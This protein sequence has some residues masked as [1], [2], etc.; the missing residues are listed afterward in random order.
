MKNITINSDRQ[1]IINVFV[2]E[3]VIFY[4]FVNI[5]GCTI[6]D[7]TKVGSFVE[8]QKNAVIGK[9]CKISSHSFICEG[10]QI[11]DNTFIGHNVTFINDKYPQA[12]NDLGELKT[13]NDWEVVRTYIGNKVSIGSGATI[14]CGLQIGD[15]AVIGAGSV[16]TKDVQAGT[17]VAGNPA[18]F[19]KKL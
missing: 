1:S 10:V 13:E 6:G 12:I 19:R 18:V 3:N 8:I 2:G 16:V 5:Y 7:E 15:G 17:I 11:G 4:N 9:R 14:L